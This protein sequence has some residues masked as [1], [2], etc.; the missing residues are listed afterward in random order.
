MGSVDAPAIV[1][2]ALPTP[3]DGL[4]ALPGAR[5]PGAI[6]TWCNTSTSTRSSPPASGFHGTPCICSSSCMP[7][8]CPSDAL[9][10]VIALTA[11][12]P[13]QVWGSRAS[14]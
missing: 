12:V 8:M 11:L 2:L 13:S 7:H 10:I 9:L 5:G 1:A 6:A 14:P 4:P 3:V